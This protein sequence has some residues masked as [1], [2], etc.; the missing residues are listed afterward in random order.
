M[1]TLI[2]KVAILILV[3]LS[4]LY[5]NTQ[6]KI[7]HGVFTTFDNILLLNVEIKI[8]STK[9]VMLICRLPFIN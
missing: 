1:N 4:A 9:Q 2:E 8:S 5:G 7:L 6:E 3:M